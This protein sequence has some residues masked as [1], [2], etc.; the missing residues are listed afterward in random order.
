MSDRIYSAEQERI[1]KE[2][3]SVGACLKDPVPVG[4]DLG[5]CNQAC[6]GTG[7][8]PTSPS[9]AVW[10]PNLER[11]ILDRMDYHMRQARELEALW[12][13]LPRELSYQATNAL[14]QLLLDAKPRF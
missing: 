2:L 3:Y 5:A 8:S 1:R 14:A 7:T 9:S 6:G 11:M 12:N 10:A 4:P 13:A